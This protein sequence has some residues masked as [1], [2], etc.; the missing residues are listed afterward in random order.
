MCCYELKK[1]NKQTHKP[2]I[3]GKTIIEQTIKKKKN[4]IKQLI[5]GEKSEFT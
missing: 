2:K 4:K 3:N 5:N 1:T